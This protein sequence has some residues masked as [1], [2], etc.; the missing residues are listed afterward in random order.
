MFL[1]NFIYEFKT[2]LR[3]KDLIFWLILFPIILGAFFK[4]AFDG[5]YEK[6]TKYSTVDAA[7]VETTEDKMFRS[8]I[9]DMEKSDTP[10][11][12][13]KFTDEKKALDMLKNGDVS[14]I[15]YTGSE[16]KLTVAETGV[17]QVVLKSFVEKYNLRSRIISKAAANDPESVSKAAAAMTEETNAIK[18]IPLTEG[19]TNNFIQYFYNLLAMVALFGSTTGLHITHVNQAN[20]SA[21]GARKC[22]SPTPK[23]ISIYSSLLAS[24]VIQSACMILSVS[25]LQFILRVDFGSRLPLVYA[26]AVLGG[27]TGVSMG[28][29]IGSIGRFSEN[30]KAGISVSGSLLLC[31]MS[32]LMVGGMKTVVEQ[33][34]PWF[35]KINAA[36]VIS[37]SFYCLNIYSNFSRFNQTL[38]TMVITSAVFTLLGLALTRR[39]KYASL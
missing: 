37:D 25:Y 7:V 3:T 10:L 23:S 6:T 17:E 11:L 21:L 2:A 9:K 35:N 20:L 14:G 31:F 26:A 15:I 12:N 13:V 38:I 39:K 32:G 5:L 22:C 36:A 27:I 19:D 4:F 18:Q 24:Y 29:F 1:H 16:L 34:A 28:F 8:V 33:K 30:A